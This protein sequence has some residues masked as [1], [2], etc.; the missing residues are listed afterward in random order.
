MFIEAFDVLI[1]KACIIC[2][3]RLGRSDVCPGCLPI[4][5]SLNTSTCI[6][7]HSTTLESDFQCQACQMFPRIYRRMRYLWNYNS[8][9]TR[10]FINCMKYK[11]S[12]KLAKKSGALLALELE[13]L[14]P[15]ADWDLIIPIPSAKQSI[16]ERLFNQCAY[17]AE[18]IKLGSSICKRTKLDLLCLKHLGYKCVQAS[19]PHSQRFRNVRH[20]FR[21]SE[22]AVRGKKILLIDDVITTGSTTTAACL[23]LLNSGAEYVDVAALARSEIWHEFRARIYFAFNQEN[24]FNGQA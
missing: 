11:P 13:N 19:L 24:V 6:H 22:Q 1:P 8:H 21:A 12:I 20:S 15:G 2:A 7:C 23:E 10:V 3:K 16:K 17:I 14:F 5:R 18:Q 4:N 9:N